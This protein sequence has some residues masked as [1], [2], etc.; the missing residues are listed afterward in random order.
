[1]QRGGKALIITSYSHGKCVLDAFSL[2][3]DGFLKS[4]ITE[5]MLPFPEEE[6]PK[7]LAEFREQVAQMK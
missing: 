1:M 2:T 3:D 4:A 5:V 7:R 6:L